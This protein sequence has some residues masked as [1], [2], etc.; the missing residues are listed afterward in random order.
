M[1]RVNTNIKIRKMVFQGLLFAMALVLSLLESMLPVLPML[2]PGIKL[3]LSNI[4]TMYALFTLGPGSGFTIAILKSYFVFLMRGGVAGALSLAGGCTAVLLMLVI[5]TLPGL[6]KNYL[7]LSIFGAVG[8]NAGQLVLARFILGTQQI[9]FLLPLLLL[10]GVG[11][12]VVTGLVLKAV[13]PY[14]NRL[15][16]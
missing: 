7:L 6:R 12:G 10:A 5:A 11:M 13:M 1:G 3:G 14:I 16:K 9:F 2:P 15:N 4:V 8:H